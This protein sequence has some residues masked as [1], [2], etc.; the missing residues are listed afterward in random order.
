ME[1]KYSL[2]EILEMKDIRDSVRK[3]PEQVPAALGV[4]AVLMGDVVIGAAV[5]SVSGGVFLARK[6]IQRRRANRS[7]E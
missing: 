4:G 5:I 3:T 7:A 2:E 6:L 1:R